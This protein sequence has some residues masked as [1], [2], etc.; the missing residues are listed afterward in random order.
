MYFRRVVDIPDAGCSYE[1]I[2]DTET[3]HDAMAGW[4]DRM[5]LS[6]VALNKRRQNTWLCLLHRIKFML[7][8]KRFPPGLTSVRNLCKRSFG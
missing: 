4:E 8:W 2:D 5:Y 3:D 6:R 7:Q 1:T